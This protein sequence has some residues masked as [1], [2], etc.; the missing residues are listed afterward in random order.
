MVGFH[1]EEGRK[2]SLL[3]LFTS[4]SICFV[5]TD[6]YIWGNPREVG[7]PFT[8]EN[9]ESSYAGPIISRAY[10]VGVDDLKYREFVKG[11]S[12]VFTFSFDGRLINLTF[13]ALFV[14]KQI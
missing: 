8:D 5:Y 14:H 10:F 7:T 4:C 1:E 11:K 2:S 12:I 6:S 13:I 3:W 9:N